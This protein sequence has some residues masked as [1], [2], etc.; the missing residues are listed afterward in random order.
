MNKSS[1]IPLNDVRAMKRTSSVGSGSDYGLEEDGEHNTTDY[2]LQAIDTTGSKKI[3]L[4]HDVSLVHLEPET[5]KETEYYNFVCEIPKF[6]RYVRQTFHFRLFGNNSNK[7]TLLTLRY[8]RY[9][10]ITE[11][12]LKS[13][14][15]RP[16]IQSNKT[17]RRGCYVK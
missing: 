10:H 1:L 5:R 4:W 12:S 3:S 8:L 14:L 13:R 15:P 6:S 11:K 9:I 7:N 2:R 16:E 17:P